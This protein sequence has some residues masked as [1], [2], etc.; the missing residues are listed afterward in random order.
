MCTVDNVWCCGDV[1][2]AK[3]KT[4]RRVAFH[5]MLEF[6]QNWLNSYG[7]Q[8]LREFCTSGTSLMVELFD[9]SSTEGIIYILRNLVCSASQQVKLTT[10]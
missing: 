5:R 10:F 2:G 3:S 9:E 7:E 1:S 4:E 6:L 8:F